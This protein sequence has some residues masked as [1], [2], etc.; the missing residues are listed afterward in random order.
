MKWDVIRIWD[1]LAPGHEVV[2]CRIIQKTEAADMLSDIGIN[3]SLMC[4]LIRRTRTKEWM[5]VWQLVSNHL[6][7]VRL[8][9]LLRD[10]Y[11]TGIAY[12]RIELHMIANTLEI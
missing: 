7:A 12:G 4:D 11:F 8:D 6:D 10:S 2:A 3:P 9:D 1:A 5:P